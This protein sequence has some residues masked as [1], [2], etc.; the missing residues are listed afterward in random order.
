MSTWQA[1]QNSEL[2]LDEIFHVGEFFILPTWRISRLWWSK[3]WCL[4]INRSLENLYAVH[5]V[6]GG[7]NDKTGVVILVF[8]WGSS[9][10]LGSKSKIHCNRYVLTQ[11]RGWCNGTCGP[12]QMGRV[13]HHKS[14]WQWHEQLGQPRSWP[15]GTEAA[16]ERCPWSRAQR[17]GSFNTLIP[18]LGFPARKTVGR[19]MEIPASLLR[20]GYVFPHTLRFFFFRPG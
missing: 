14:P 7:S 3:R 1:G 20:R 6:W 17:Q 11:G 2:L 10:P 13:A 18:T 15:G 12:W 16:H 4:H 5:V 9:R 19:E 8:A